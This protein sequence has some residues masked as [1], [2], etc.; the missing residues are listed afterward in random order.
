MN[1]EKKK[2]KRKGGRREREEGGSRFLFECPLTVQLRHE[3]LMVP[4]KE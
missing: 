4:L 2:R 1:D 3:Q